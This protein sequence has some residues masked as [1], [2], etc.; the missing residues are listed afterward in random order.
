MQPVFDQHDLSG[1]HPVRD[2]GGSVNMWALS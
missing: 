2:C 1:R